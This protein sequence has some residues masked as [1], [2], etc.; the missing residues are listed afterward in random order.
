MQNN[1]PS[2]SSTTVSQVDMSFLDND[3]SGAPSS[4]QIINQ[5]TTDQKPQNIFKRNAPDMSFLDEETK[6]KPAVQKP[7]TGKPE[8]GA[9]EDTDTNK[10]PISKEDL[11]DLLNP[12]ADS[13]ESGTPDTGKGRPKTDKSGL[14][15]TFT[16]LIADNKLIPFDDGKPLEEYTEKDFEELIDANFTERERALRDETPKEFFDSLPKE[17]QYAA[18]YHAD[19]G[20]D[21][22]GLFRAL[23]HVEEVRSLDVNVESDQEQIV[24]SYLKA[25]Q[26]GNDSEIDEEISTWKDLGRLATQAGKF[27]PKLD[28]MQEQVIQAQLADQASKKES[29]QKASENYVNN[30]FTALKTGEIN[31]L[32]LDKKTQSALY[33]GLTQPQYTSIT[34]K[35]TNLLGHLLEKHQFVDPNYP[36]IAEAL[37]LLSNPEEYRASLKV[38]GKN[39]A[40]EETVRTLKTAAAQKI[41]T[42]AG[43]NEPEKNNTRGIKRPANFFAR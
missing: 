13:N 1:N 8:E 32:R 40:T 37:W 33:V 35:Q 23:S 29:Q 14:V 26:F 30:V 16:K 15:K 41:H 31:G 43:D 38:Q 34:G 7:E 18:K 28:A 5:E 17:L 25:T 19:G 27:K 39:A 11:N 21:L 9:P 10:P 42:G 2:N 6:P 36:L 3:F 20:T 4:D 12:D 22:K 24:R